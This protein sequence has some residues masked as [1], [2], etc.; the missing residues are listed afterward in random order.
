M[1]F[2]KQEVRKLGLH[3]RVLD[4]AIT[5]GNVKHINTSCARSVL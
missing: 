2:F 5:V 4:E 3:F 1:N